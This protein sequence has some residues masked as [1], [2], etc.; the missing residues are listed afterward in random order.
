MSESA[1]DNAPETF[2]AHLDPG[3]REIVYFHGKSKPNIATKELQ[4]HWV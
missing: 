4:E 1:S 3:I 2:W